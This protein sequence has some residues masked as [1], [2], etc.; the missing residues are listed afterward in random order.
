MERSEFRLRFFSSRPAPFFSRCKF[1]ALNQGSRPPPPFASSPPSPSVTSRYAMAD[2]T[3][4]ERMLE[5]KMQ[6][7]AQTVKHSNGDSKDKDK[8][9]KHKK[10]KH[11][12]SHKS[13]KSE[14]KD[15]R[16]RHRSPT[17]PPMASGKR[18][19][20]NSELHQLAQTMNRQGPPQPSSRDQSSSS[21]KSA[22]REKSP[23]LTPEER[24]LRTVFCK[25]ST[26]QSHLTVRFCSSRY[27]I[28]SDDSPT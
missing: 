12:K 20:V 23:E 25:D 18:R 28:G 21:A 6:E 15:D 2:D 24:D 27:A 22:R 1:I 7:D 5:E 17:P 13:H 3:E 16:K 19:D 4:I 26:S 8:D 10:H 14:K 9:K 11:H